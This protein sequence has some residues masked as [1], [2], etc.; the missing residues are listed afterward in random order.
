M[1]TVS[2]KP[3]RQ[4]KRSNCFI[5][6]PR[7]RRCGAVSLSSLRCGSVRF[8]ENAIPTVRFVAV[9][10]CRAPYG[11]VR[12]YFMSYGPNQ[13][14]FSDIV[15]PT[16]R[17]GAVRCGAV[18][19]VFQECKNPSVRWCAVNLTEAR[20]TD[21][22]IRTV[23]NSV[24]FIVFSVG[25]TPRPFDVIFSPSLRTPTSSLLRHVTPACFRPSSHCRYFARRLT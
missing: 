12:C 20:R 18:R 10:R 15:K 11:A 14:V 8:L 3:H 7:R 17:C 1:S 22:K 4:K 19:C 13:C 21:R 23:K 5:T 9:F 2:S 6:V 16:V 25:S 24:V